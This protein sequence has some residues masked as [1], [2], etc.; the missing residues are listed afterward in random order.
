MKTVFSFIKTTVYGGILFLIPLT[1]I[2]V[3][4]DNIYK[5]IFKI[6]SPIAV[7]VGVEKLGGKI[8]VILIVVFL[9]ILICFI[10]GLILKLGFG[11]KLHNK[12]EDIALKFIPGYEKLK[13]ETI[14][15]VDE[16]ITGKV[17][18][19]Y[20]DW[21]AVIMKFN[22]EWKIV[23][24]VEESEKGL[25]TVFEPGSPD[26]L[27]GSTKILS[28][29]EIE[30]IPIDKEKAIRYLKKYGSGTSDFIAEKI[31]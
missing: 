9:L 28:D 1:I 15:K 16:N 31:N 21:N 13:S 5:K 6:V 11:K 12:I 26:F 23:F 29:S 18:N 30:I 14:K 25:V 2:I 20:D 19:V 27:K 17:K 4:L 7:A 8:A 22:S 3:V 24:I 10:A